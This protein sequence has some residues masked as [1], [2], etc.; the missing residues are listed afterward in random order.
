MTI[1][2]LRAFAKNRFALSTAS[3]LLCP[4]APNTTQTISVVGFSSSNL[5]IV[6]PQPISMSSLCAPRHKILK[7]ESRCLANSKVNIH[8]AFYSG[9]LSP[10]DV[11]H[12]SQGALPRLYI[13]VN[14]LCSLNV[15]SHLNW[16][17]R[18]QV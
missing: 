14:S 8:L 18:Y 17:D 9:L 15:S 7:T 6:P 10:A 16:S 2:F 12:T 13:S 5:R 11:F 1:S 3:V 4:D